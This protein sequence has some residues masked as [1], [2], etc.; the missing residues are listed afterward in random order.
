MYKILIVDDEKTLLYATQYYLN[1]QGFNT[2]I[3]S[4]SKNGLKLIPII[5]PDLIILDVIMPQLDGYAFIEKLRV[6]NE[7]LSI[8][9][10][11]V[12]AKG[13]TQDRIKG[14]Q[15]GCSAYLSKPFDPE[16]LIVIVKNIL[17]RKNQLVK[18]IKEV[19][20]NI[21][22]V[23]LYLNKQYMIYQKNA[24]YMHLTPREKVVINYI[25]KGLQNKEIAQIVKT[26][27]RNVERYVTRL[28]RKTNTNNRTSLVRHIYI[29]YST[30]K[31]NDGNRTRE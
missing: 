15:L 16:E 30:F 17:R 3:A 31:A 11:F 8:P 9:F 23:N 19:T 22:D 28:L 14:Y 5:K 29:N 2:F 21:T 26:S 4:S 24:A 12:T 6:Q 20:S 18:E 7:S 27:V 1:L 25:L 10:V 13:M